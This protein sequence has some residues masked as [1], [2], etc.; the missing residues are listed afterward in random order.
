MGT[1]DQPVLVAKGDDRRIDWGWL[2]VAAS[3]RDGQDGD[4]PRHAGPGDVRPDRPGGRQ[5][6]RQMPRPANDHWPVLSVAMD[7]GSVGGEPVEPASDDRL[8]R[9]LFDRIFRPQAAGLVAARRS[10]D[11]RKDAGGRR[12]RL[13]LGA[14]SSCEEF[15]D[16]LAGGRPQD[17]ARP[18]M[19]ICARWPIGR[20]SPPTSWWPM[21]TAS[22]CFSRRNVFRT[23]R[24][25]R[26]T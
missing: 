18:S 22:R 21:P 8:R 23:A 17:R 20:R 25:A 2:L 13:C 14:A 26:S 15:D 16:A 1:K 5:G 24:S 4:R 12:A 7:L 10:D 11:G 6:R 19:S 9:R 3:D